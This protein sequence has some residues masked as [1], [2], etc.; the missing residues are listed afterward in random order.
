MRVCV[1]FIKSTK[2]K[3]VDHF[4]LYCVKSLLVYELKDLLSFSHHKV[5]KGQMIQIKNGFCLP[6]KCSRIYIS[7]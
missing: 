2:V 6:K 5:I 1:I 4:S 7:A 3:F